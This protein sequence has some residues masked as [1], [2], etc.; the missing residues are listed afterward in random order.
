VIL[1]VLSV[2]LQHASKFYPSCQGASSPMPAYIRTCT[3]TD[4]RLRFMLFV[5]LHIHVPAHVLRPEDPLALIL[6]DSSY[7]SKPVQ[8]AFALLS[9]QEAD[10]NSRLRSGVFTR[11]LESA[12]RRAREETHTSSS[13]DTESYESTQDVTLRRG[14]SGGIGLR[15]YQPSL[16]GPCIVIGLVSSKLDSMRGN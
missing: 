7:T 2:Y 9:E 4:R 11:Y 1:Q 3:E 12:T 8:E 5:A 10:L 6:A 13:G 15:F 14:E 16:P